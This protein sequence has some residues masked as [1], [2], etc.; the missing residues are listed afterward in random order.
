[1]SQKGY[2]QI[3]IFY[4][5]LTCRY[6]QFGYSKMDYALKYTGQHNW[7]IES[8]FEIKIVKIDFA[9]QVT[10]FF[11]KCTHIW[12]VF[13]SRFIHHGFDITLIIFIH[14]YTYMSIHH[15]EIRFQIKLLFLSV[16]SCCWLLYLYL[17]IFWHRF[18]YL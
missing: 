3:L 5:F 16:I 8:I 1:M 18:R 10:H 4:N 2:V 13:V 7:N 14:P 12:G 11:L 15:P 6:P 17:I 9:Q